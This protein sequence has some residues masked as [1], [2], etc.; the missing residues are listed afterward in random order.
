MQ[1]LGSIIGTAEDINRRKS[2]LLKHMNVKKRMYHSHRLSSGFKT[3]YFIAF[4][5][6]IFL[7]NCELWTLTSN[8]EKRLD[9]FHRDS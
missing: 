3:L 2:L 9:A 5:E 7:Y 1:I 8:D 4:A 6:S